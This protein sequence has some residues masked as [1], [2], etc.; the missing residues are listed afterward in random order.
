MIR[1]FVRAIFGLGADSRE[2]SRSYVSVTKM[3]K[4]GEPKKIK[5]N[6]PQK[7]C[8]KFYLFQKPSRFTISFIYPFYRKFYFSVRQVLAIVSIL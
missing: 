6:T 1:I 5:Q 7:N 3:V 2:L 8:R 4:K